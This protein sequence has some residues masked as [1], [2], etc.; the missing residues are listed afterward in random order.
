MGAI[1]E[2]IKFEEETLGFLLKKA[3]EGNVFAIESL[4]RIV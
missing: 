3:S 1:V 4:K 2:K